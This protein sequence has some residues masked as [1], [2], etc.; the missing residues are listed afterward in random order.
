MNMR[1]KDKRRIAQQIR[2][3]AALRAIRRHI[4]KGSNSPRLKA[5]RIQESIANV[6]RVPRRIQR[7]F[8]KTTIK[9]INKQIIIAP[10]D[11]RLIS[12][13]EKCLDFFE[14]I[15]NFEFANIPQR[16]KFVRISLKRVQQIDYAAISILTAISEDLKSKNIF[17]SGDFPENATCKQFL[18]DSGFLNKMFDKHNRPFPR[19]EKSDVIFFETGCGTLSE[20]DNMK[21]SSL[22]RNVVGHLTGIPKHNPSIKTIILEIC[23]NSIEWSGTNN[24]QWLLGVMY[25]EKKVIFTVVDIGKGILETLYRKFGKR[26]ADFITLKTEADVLMGAYNKKYGSNTQQVNRN[27]GLPSVKASFQDG[28]INNLIVMTNNVILHFADQEKTTTFAENSPCFKGTFYQWEMDV[29]CVKLL[30]S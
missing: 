28:K 7:N 23:G 17:I 6:P 30:N 15:R 12:N 4:P 14:K 5:K 24:K 16:R 2:I 9:K 22:V 19:S 1:K 21:I 13:R 18:F 8:N 29:N 25:E 27:K 10:C 20:S 3:R 11:F 26:A